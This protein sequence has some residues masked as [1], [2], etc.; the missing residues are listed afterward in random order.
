MVDLLDIAKANGVPLTLWTDTRT[1][2][3]RNES[4]HAILV[5]VSD[6]RRFEVS[7][8][9]VIVILG[10]GILRIERGPQ[11]GKPGP[12]RLHLQLGDAKGSPQLPYE[13]GRWLREM[14]DKIKNWFGGGTHIDLYTPP[15]PHAEDQQTVGNWLREGIRLPII[16]N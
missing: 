14:W 2:L 16:I 3:V 15:S 12:A 13:V 11:H 1:Q 4:S 8:G 10:K 9:R 6:G 7:P 5:N